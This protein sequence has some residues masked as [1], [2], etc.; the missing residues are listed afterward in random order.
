MNNQTDL[1]NPN[2][3]IQLSSQDYGEFLDPWLQLMIAGNYIANQ[4]FDNLENGNLPNN[5]LVNERP[6]TSVQVISS[7]DNHN[8]VLEISDSNNSDHVNIIYEFT[9]QLYGYIEFWIQSN[10]SDNYFEIILKSNQG[11]E[12]VYIGINESQFFYNH[13]INGYTTLTLAESNV[14]YHFKIKFNNSAGLYDLAINNALFSNI[15]YYTSVDNITKLEFSTQIS[16]LGN[17]A[18]YLDAIDFSFDPEWYEGR[19]MG[20]FDEYTGAYTFSGDIL[21][22]SP[23][24]WNDASS[25]ITSA[26]IQGGLDGHASVLKIQD[27]DNTSQAKIIRDGL[28]IS[29]DGSLEFY[30]HSDNNQNAPT[31]LE[32]KDSI[33]NKIAISLASYL[34]GYF[35][36]KH[37]GSWSQL[38][39]NESLIPLL[40]DSN[41]WYH[42][43]VFMNMASQ[44]FQIKI[45]DVQYYWN[46]GGTPSTDIPFYDSVSIADTISIFSDI[47]TQISYSH[48]YDAID[49]S[50]N[51]S[52]YFIGRN[53]YGIFAFSHEESK[54]EV[55]LGCESIGPENEIIIDSSQKFD[56]NFGFNQYFLDFGEN[57][58]N[59]KLIVSNP[60][61]INELYVQPVILFDNDSI[62][63]D[64]INSQEFSF[65]GGGPINILAKPDNSFWDLSIL[66]DD[67]TIKNPYN[68]SIPYSFEN[69]IIGENPSSWLSN[70][71]EDVMNDQTIR[72]VDQIDGH[73]NIVKYQIRTGGTNH[74]PSANANMDYGQMQSSVEFWYKTNSTDSGKFSFC[75]SDVTTTSAFINISWNYD[76]HLWLF[77]K[78]TSVPNS[79][80][81][82]LIDLGVR[83]TEWHHM[84]IWWSYENAG[85]DNDNK[86]MIW[87]DNNLKAY[88]SDWWVC[89]YDGLDIWE[90]YV[91]GSA[92][93]S[94]DLYIDAVDCSWIDGYFDGRSLSYY[95]YDNNVFPLIE[96]LSLNDEYFDFPIKIEPS[97]NHKLKIIG[98]GSIDLKIV[99]DCDY[100][101]DMINTKE[102]IKENLDPF[103][104]DFWCWYGSGAHEGWN[105]KKTL[106]SL[107]VF[108]PTISNLYI[109][110]ESGIIS[111]LLIDSIEYEEYISPYETIDLGELSK[112]LHSL[113]FKATGDQIENYFSMNLSRM[114]SFQIS[115]NPLE[116]EIVKI[117]S[118]DEQLD[119]DGDGL[120]NF[121]ESEVGLNYFNPDY[122]DDGLLDGYDTSPFNKIEF[123]PNE[124]IQV[125]FPVEK[126]KTTLITILVK[127][128]EIDYSSPYMNWRDEKNVTIIPGMRI[129][130]NPDTNISSL[131]K[132]INKNVKSYSL[133][134]DNYNYNP[135]EP[136]CP[137]DYIPTY[138][139]SESNMIEPF[140]VT[141]NSWA[142][143]LIYEPNHPAKMDK[144]IDFRFDLVWM[145]LESI[146][147]SPEPRLLALF[148]MEE[149]MIIQSFQKQEVSDIEYQIINTDSI[150]EIKLLESLFINPSLISTLNGSVDLNE[151]IVLNG[152]SDLPSFFIKISS[153]AQE[154]SILLSEFNLKSNLL[155]KG[156]SRT[157]DILLQGI[158][159]IDPSTEFIG[160]TIKRW[161]LTSGAEI[162]DIKFIINNLQPYYTETCISSKAQHKIF[163]ETI[164]NLNFNEI[165]S[166]DVCYKILEVFKS[167]IIKNLEDFK[168]E[169][170]PIILNNPNEIFQETFKIIKKG[171][172]FVKS[173][174]KAV[175]KAYEFI[176]NQKYLS[177]LKEMD[178]AFLCNLVTKK[179]LNDNIDEMANIYDFLLNGAGDDNLKGNTG[180]RN[181]VKKFKHFKNLDPKDV[182][183]VIRNFK[184]NNEGKEEFLKMNEEISETL[185]GSNKKKDMAYKYDAGDLGEISKEYK[186]NDITYNEARELR[187]YSSSHQHGSGDLPILE[188]EINQE[189]K[190][191]STLSGIK[192]SFKKNC[193]SI[194][195]NGLDLINSFISLGMAINKIQI[196]SISI[197][198]YIEENNE[199]ELEFLIDISI[200]ITIE[201]LGI[202][203]ACFDITTT[204]ILILKDLGIITIST[205]T[206]KAIGVISALVTGIISQII[207]ILNLINDINADPHFRNVF[208]ESN[209]AIAQ[210]VW[211][212]LSVTASILSVCCPIV[213]LPMLVMV[214]A[215]NLIITLFNGF[216][217]F[218]EKFS[219][220]NIDLEIPD[221]VKNGEPYKNGDRIRLNI[222]FQNKIQPLVWI[223][224]FGTF[225]NIFLT[226]PGLAVYIT[227]SIRATSICE[228]PFSGTVILGGQI[229]VGPRGEYGDDNP[230][231]YN[232][233]T[234]YLQ[235]K[236]LV[237][238]DTI[239][240]YDPNNQNLYLKLN[241]YI[242]AE[243]WEWYGVPVYSGNVDYEPFEDEYLLYIAPNKEKL[244][245][246]SIANFSKGLEPWDP[247]DY[248]AAESFSSYNEGD[249]ASEYPWSITSSPNAPVNILNSL[250]GHKKVLHL[251]DE[252]VSNEATASYYLEEGASKGS[253][254]FWIRTIN[255][256]A[257]N[258]IKFI[259]ESSEIAKFSIKD[260]KFKIWNNNLLD[261]QDLQSAINNKWYHI[262][263]EFDCSK[264]YISYYIDNELSISSIPLYGIYSKIDVIKFVTGLLDINAE[265]SIDAIDYSWS[266][267]YFDGRNYI[268]NSTNYNGEE[269]FDNYF[270][271]EFKSKGNWIILPEKSEQLSV[272]IIPTFDGHK[273]V[274][275]I[276]DE[277]KMNSAK[278]I[279]NLSNS[280]YE[281]IIEFWIRSS[282]CY[283][284]HSIELSESY[285]SFSKIS[286]FNGSLY[287]WNITGQSSGQWTEIMDIESNKWIHIRIEFNLYLSKI[288]I[289]VN[290]LK[291]LN[292]KNA[293]SG[294]NY[295]NQL[296]FYSSEE[297]TQFNYEF[298]IDAIDFSWSTGY[299]KGRNK[300]LEQNLQIE[301]SSFD[302]TPHFSFDQYDA[303]AI[304]SSWSITS[305][306]GSTW[307]IKDQW[308]GRN[309][310]YMCEH[311][312]N[313]DQSSPVTST[314]FSSPQISGTIEWW[315]YFQNSSNFSPY[316][317]IRDGAD[318]TY[319]QICG[320]YLTGRFESLLYD[321]VYQEIDETLLSIV[322]YQW[323]HLKI[324]FECSN[325]GY[326]GLSQ[327]TY[328][329]YINGIRYGPLYFTDTGENVDSLTTLYFCGTGGPY[330][331]NW[332]QVYDD[333]DFSWAPG[334]FEGRNIVDGNTSTLS[335][336]TFNNDKIGKNP[337]GW[338]STTSGD[339]Q[340]QVIQYKSERIKLVELENIDNFHSSISTTF[341]SQ[342]MKTI[343]FYYLTSDSNEP[344]YMSILYND[345]EKIQ[346]YQ[347]GSYFKYNYQ[348]SHNITKC[349][350]NRWYH[351]RINYDIT[352]KKWNIIINDNL[353]GPFNFTWDSSYLN[354]LKIRT[355]GD[356]SYKIYIDEVDFSCA[357]GY[358]FGRNK[359]SSFN[360]YEHFSNYSFTCDSNG[361]I[362]DGW[363]IV[364]PSGSDFRIIEE[365]KGHLKVFE[366]Y[367]GYSND[368]IFTQT[369]FTEKYYGT[370]EWWWSTS[371]INS[372]HTTSLLNSDSDE[373]IQV[374][375][376]DL[377]KLQFCNYDFNQSAWIW[378]DIE[379]DEIVENEWYQF[380]L[381][382]DCS[383]AGGYKDLKSNQFYFTVNNFQYGPFNFTRESAD[384]T[385]L[386]FSGDSSSHDWYQWFDAIDFSWADNYYEGRNQRMQYH[387]IQAAEDFDKYMEGLFGSNEN[388]DIIPDMSVNAYIISE[389]DGHKDILALEDESTIN[390]P[391]ALLNLGDGSRYGNIEFW[392]RTTNATKDNKIT[393]LNK[394]SEIAAL[395]I[396]INEFQFW[397]IDT[398]TWEILQSAT[399]NQWY[400]VK[401]QFDCAL[402]II[403]YY[404]DQKLRATSKIYG[405]DAI[406]DCIEFRPEF[407]ES[408]LIM[409]IDAI[410]YSWAPYY[411]DGRNL[412]QKSI[413][414]DGAESFDDYEPG[415]PISNS[416]ENG[417]I[418]DDI[419]FVGSTNSYG[420]GDED[421]LIVSYE[422]DR[423]DHENWQQL[424]GNVNQDTVEDVVLD[425]EGNICVTGRTY[426]LISEGY[427]GYVAKYSSEGTL[428]WFETWGSAASN[429]YYS[430]WG[431]GIAID[432]ANNIYVTGSY[433]RLSIPWDDI[434]VGKYHS[435][436]TLLWSHTWN[437]YKNQGDIGYGIAVSSSGNVYVTGSTWTDSG[438]YRNELVLL[439]YD[440]SGNL[441]W[442]KTWG[443]TQ[444]ECGLDIVVDINEKIYIS[445]FTANYGAGLYD[446]CAWIFDSSGT[447]EW[448]DYWGTPNYDQGWGIC[449][450]ASNNFYITGNVYNETHYDAFIRKYNESRS[451]IWYKTFGGDSDDAAQ[452]ICLVNS[453][454]VLITGHTKSYG[455]GGSDVYL[456]CFDTYNGSMLLNQT[457][458]GISDDFGKSLVIK[459]YSYVQGENLNPYAY[460]SENIYEHKDV[461][462]L[463]H[464]EGNGDGRWN[465][466]IPTSDETGIIEFWINTNDASQSSI[467][468]VLN[469]SQKAWVFSI[470]ANEF[471][472]WNPRINDWSTIKSSQSNEWYHVRIDFNF[473]ISKYNVTINGDTVLEGA[474]TLGADR[475]NKINFILAGYSLNASFESYIDAIDYS[476]AN[477]Y[478]QG[479]NFLP[480]EA[481]YFGNE[482]FTSYQVGPFISSGQWVITGNNPQLEILDEVN[483]HRTCLKL[484]D[485]N[486]A[487]YSIA[488]M[489]LY[490]KRNNGSL[491]FWYLTEDPTKITW[492]GLKDDSLQV[493]IA[494][495]TFSNNFNFWNLT[496][497]NWQNAKNCIANIWYHHKIVFNHTSDKFDWYINDELILFQA[498]SFS[499]D[500]ILYFEIHTSDLDSGVCSYLDALDF[501]WAN[502]YDN[503]RNLIPRLA[504]Y[505]GIESFKYPEGNFLPVVNWSL[506]I[507]QKI[508]SSISKNVLGHNEILCLDDTSE[509]EYASFTYLMSDLDIIGSI[510]FWICSTNPSKMT[511]ISLNEENLPVLAIAINRKKFQYWDLE[512][513]R[514][515]DFSDCLKN[516]WYHLRINI[517]LNINEFSV[518]LNDVRFLNSIQTYSRNY[519]NVINFLTTGYN[520]QDS[521]ESYIDS[522]DYSWAEGYYYGRNKQIEPSS[523]NFRGKFSFNN[524]KIGTN[525]NEW[526]TYENYESSISITESLLDHNKI[527][528]IVSENDS[529]I[530][531]NEWKIGG[532]GESWNT[533]TDE[534]NRSIVESP[535]LSS[536]GGILS[537]QLNSHI[538]S[539]TCSSGDFY[540]IYYYTTGSY[541]NTRYNDGLYWEIAHAYNLYQPSAMQMRLYFNPAGPGVGYTYDR[542]YMS[543]NAR[544]WDG[545][546]YYYCYHIFTW[547]GTS[548][549]N[550]YEVF[551]ATSAFKN[552]NAE[553]TN[554]ELTD[555]QIY[556]RI[557]RGLHVD[558]G[559]ESI[560]YAY[561]DWEWKQYETDVL[562][563]SPIK[564]FEDPVEIEKITI[565][566]TASHLAKLHDWEYQI[567]NASTSLWGDWNSFTPD[568]NGE[569]E[570]SE[571]LWAKGIRW[572]VR[573]DRF[574]LAS[575]PTTLN[576]VSVS[577]RSWDLDELETETPKLAYQGP[578]YLNGIYEFWVNLAQ[579]DS[580]MNI[581]AS[582]N[583]NLIDGFILFDIRPDGLWD[584][585]YKNQL[586]NDS[587]L[588]EKINLGT[589]QANQWY[590]MKVAWNLS[591][592]NTDSGHLEMWLDG[593][594]KVDVN[595][596]AFVGF[597][598]INYFSFEA[599][600]PKTGAMFIDAI[601]FSWETDYFDGRNKELNIGD[602]IATESFTNYTAGPFIS[603]GQWTIS[604][605]INTR[606]SISSI[607]DEHHQVMCLND[608][609]E[610]EHVSCIYDFL[611]PTSN[612]NLEFWIRSTDTTKITMFEI[613]ENNLQSISLCIKDS[614]FKYWNFNDEK[615]IEF[616]EAD[617]NEW[618]KIRI[619]FNI[620]SN[621]LT[622]NASINDDLV[623]QDIETSSSIIQVDALRFSTTGFPNQAGFETH[624]DGIN[625]SWV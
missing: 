102:E 415:I 389:I 45:N 505:D 234:S 370:I 618:Y 447:L 241:L 251:K 183:D 153:E 118:F 286:I 567:K 588:H 418:L 492:F 557:Y 592:G 332:I 202:I 139:P 26:K 297:E 127:S 538:E 301:T 482:T 216:I 581:L 246:E 69:D 363:S 39:H 148:D 61:S 552:Y 224:L 323:Y 51:D 399:K 262:K 205:F 231:T 328:Y 403:S 4:S 291:V 142:V 411:E 94:G 55:I 259:S 466:E 225:L 484:Q 397:N 206:Q 133:L 344:T 515:I 327:D 444:D 315:W 82:N 554:Y 406:I 414:F 209:K 284:N 88:V 550:F 413:N 358:F 501:S 548:S 167:Q 342:N 35:K 400:H 386:K 213:G 489:D 54:G 31:F 496:L 490:E 448:F 579:T 50:W 41:I 561:I 336:Y 274:L 512:L 9:P 63:L 333:I 250:H 115:L 500:S 178:D 83:D 372:I 571:I 465:Y 200:K 577:Y 409:Y 158:E 527:V 619:E 330:F 256:S 292:N 77:Y 319:I 28:N 219:I 70:I 283:K 214:T 385:T 289:S 176:N 594:K 15:G 57:A 507:D 615:W 478:Y 572:R 230:L 580:H 264:G 40:L 146:P 361:E 599:H 320:S 137:G 95:N 587:W 107:Y 338:I 46:D 233:S 516:K 398:Q 154:K 22:N 87:I 343:E 238:E 451:M 514:W 546:P 584:I 531:F 437:G 456:A 450:D 218:G 276:L 410:D 491:E 544:G 207:V 215:I 310:V 72:V 97:N 20:V 427:D 471:Q 387:H 442:A 196:Y 520:F 19:S 112:G 76:G 401:I 609:N 574:E 17:Y 311:L 16:Q 186:E 125:V 237:L 14:W 150:V 438:L 193:L 350:S 365:K 360:S 48:Y 464:P 42:I 391:S 248:N 485:A 551:D 138:D 242:R 68:F 43:Y 188:G 197:I 126:E 529:A 121:Y 129:F 24:D 504:E 128:P 436:G 362:P 184:N 10:N 458:G 64:N 212:G 368:E 132:M 541:P 37:S 353:Y 428:I 243:W 189:A 159:H 493:S 152:T 345:Q 106:C 535:L 52:D 5:W 355:S 204:V 383:D 135:T 392:I 356:S 610:S 539:T 266:F 144:I 201:I 412:E 476:W 257:E 268:R 339:C 185:M 443:G 614:K 612:G 426:D 294:I 408:N 85:N 73:N 93:K 470:Q 227:E 27:S 394:S 78:N 49:W 416:G 384:L 33:N 559:I 236:T 601:D 604:S 182:P 168:S 322:P 519:I 99:C 254:E 270:L 607:I 528:K 90:Q 56:A 280:P 498:D 502:D 149:K 296:H 621:Q 253:I 235:T 623:L 164:I 130:G 299:F 208:T 513:S 435:N 462:C 105:Y 593:E 495:S 371:S 483:A 402:G 348:G 67:I 25:G 100:D 346:F 124:F 123:S 373:V 429:E 469:N 329:F 422:F 382:F 534:L 349:F 265:F 570:L 166:N 432:A 536:N 453:S 111:D 62:L 6:G 281:G 589:Y 486:V 1:N 232:I 334:Y 122:D 608:E 421:G 617:S 222:E 38:Y 431:H 605:Y 170:N 29:T 439:K 169:I 379:T 217:V 313:P 116:K 247:V 357:S 255:N 452:A 337:S 249:F 340:I 480:I 425:S 302:P 510:E 369:V 155:L 565:N 103:N 307:S 300:L 180:I 613:L 530:N 622:F 575:N 543:A 21:D 84:K 375:Q 18:I 532:D 195:M 108:L 488:Y 324:D 378:Y 156:E 261:W 304:P 359:L 23:S 566:A 576:S 518:Y 487:E 308:Q 140:A 89:D 537:L 376:N 11:E 603:Q 66:L 393:F 549:G 104:P 134:N 475:I 260:K 59:H 226:I 479:R 240:N 341:S 75:F 171:T 511:V 223:H 525:P 547:A 472:Y 563:N 417:K 157:D 191:K 275:S 306:S 420:C 508:N 424:I 114:S 497:N 388:W 380:K 86:I 96:D 499:R 8:E 569:Y 434:W 162:N 523:N 556:F 198:E 553:K 287:F 573:I 220:V 454:Y 473:S 141:E 160:T 293:Y 298:F 524:D 119:Y 285:K 263:I 221:N 419:L 245:D 273:K 596:M 192:A 120:K 585:R 509:L 407:Y 131:S 181:I 460:I 377:G 445:G 457:W 74:N 390:S 625:C 433:C 598:G 110:L 455:N 203:K 228:V 364:K 555:S 165:D 558:A 92:F 117:R 316:F 271:G 136:G 81:G 521:Y 602:Y 34:D 517:N 351:I 172:K 190:P 430:D 143:N 282:D 591:S 305:T 317:Y 279:Y 395:A 177:Q 13:P 381:D 468:E 506:D 441:I 467:V 278:A 309:K 494:L 590:H 611:N 474:P 47:E 481:D 173:V 586:Q 267:G 354:C 347:D 405:S 269:S 314:T 145:V 606:A 113:I 595:N 568:E 542:I 179:Q 58:S 71:I 423:T 194:F 503:E 36:V 352:N 522:I 252:S 303:G 463:N 229:K 461:L 244:Y 79:L 366:F 147:N 109:T 624:I 277:S 318:R 32:L 335:K 374:R 312:Q 597:G 396:R 65:Y 582:S 446:A 174:I 3:S 578:N 325:G 449:L 290:G 163:E 331:N 288:N 477:G 101:E 540:V 211:I 321:N 272:K 30:I 60:E 616:A 151:K 91:D 7:Y 187:D 562:L 80:D 161:Y 326:K 620:N 526:N 459:Q 210:T 440:T 98:N 295:I 545:I 239:E 53:T 583:V 44:T 12:G 199:F 564:N 175:T 533:C 367:H 600:G 2:E 258:T 404:I 560:Q